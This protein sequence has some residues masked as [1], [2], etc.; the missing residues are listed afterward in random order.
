M[1][2][3]LLTI[4]LLAILT[5]ASSAF[6]ASP[7]KAKL[8]EA[9]KTSLAWRNDTVGFWKT[10]GWW[11]SAN[12]LTAMIRYAELTGSKDAM[13]P[14]I[15]D[16]FVKSNKHFKNYINEYYDDEGWWALAW[17]EAYKLTGVKKYLD[18]AE[19]IFAD[20]TTGWSEECGGGIFWKKPLQY[21]N[22]IAN[23]LFTLTAARLYKTTNKAQYLDWTNK[24]IEWFLN[25][26]MINP[27][28]GLVMDGTKNCIATG[29]YYTYNQGVAMAALAEAYLITKDKKYLKAANGI[30]KSTINSTNIMIDANGILKEPGN[31]NR[32][33]GADGIQFKGIFMRHLGFLNGVSKDKDYKA[34]I[35]KN[36]DSNITNNYD[37]AS[38]SYGSFWAGPFDK[39]HSGG[40]SS[41]ME[42]ILEAYALTK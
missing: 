37:T 3:K 35:L 42:C 28:T 11:N 4:S 27:T 31:S 9:A 24:N 6:A 5:F 23:N 19:V 21:K 30:A 8:D 15:E 32:S 25:S 7:Y 22:A 20:M 33:L 34:F 26:G 29:A 17:I 41:A 14:V 12:V 1:K 36:A 2:T 16:V 38:K 18:M 13:A 10:A 39:P 40:H